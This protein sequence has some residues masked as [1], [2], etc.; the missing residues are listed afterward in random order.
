MN[1]LEVV[2]MNVEEFCT[3][4]KNRM[5]N[6]I[7]DAQK[8]RDEVNAVAVGF[9]CEVVTFEDGSVLMTKEVYD[10]LKMRGAI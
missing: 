2:L 5:W 10:Y 3:K 6:C 1:N 8:A 4:Y 9:S 7:T